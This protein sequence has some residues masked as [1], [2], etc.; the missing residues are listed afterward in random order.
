MNANQ[1]QTTRKLTRKEKRAL[2]TSG[3]S[4]FNTGLQLEYVKP[5]T[6]N[7]KRVFKAFEQG[8]HLFLHGS[9]GTGKSFLSLY[10]SLRELNQNPNLNTVNIIRSVVPSRDAGFLPGSIK[11]KAAVF[12]QPYEEICSALYRRGDAYTL[13]KQRRIVNFAT[14]SYLRGITFTD[15]IIFVDECQN[16]D[17]GELHTL[18]TRVG[19][20][21]RIIFSG[22]IRQA[23]LPKSGLAHF[24]KIIR[25]MKDFE[26]VEFTVDDVVRSDLV[27][28]YLVAK[29]RI[30]TG[31]DDSN[32]SEPEVSQ[33]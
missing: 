25:A 1:I 33:A 16:M 10:L 29:E 27:K 30:E 13:L 2:R 5:L 23:D 24:I 17:S 14:T 6:D 22:D 15:C 4:T 12:E 3:G 18:I 11:D 26:F 8:K 31:H 21:C 28:R 7:Q 20:N 19:E 32:R 9:A